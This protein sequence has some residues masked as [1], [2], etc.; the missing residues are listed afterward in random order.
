MHIVRFKNWIWNS[1]FFSIKTFHLIA[2]FQ[3]SFFKEVKH[4]WSSVKGSAAL[5]HWISASDSAF[6]TFSRT[7]FYKIRSVFLKLVLTMSAVKK[8]I[9]TNSTFVLKDNHFQGSYYVQSFHFISYG[10]WIRLIR[11]VEWRTR[12]LFLLWRWK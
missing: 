8:C 6:I 4:F 2:V 9:N 11:Q 10:K 12:K 5:C 1:N 7:D 3:I